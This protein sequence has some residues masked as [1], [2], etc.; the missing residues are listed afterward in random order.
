MFVLDNVIAAVALPVVISG[1]DRWP[2]IAVLVLAP[3]CS[4]VAC[5]LA[6]HYWPRMRTP[7]AL[8]SVV[9]GYSLCEVGRYAW[10]IAVVPE[11]LASVAWYLGLGG[12]TVGHVALFAI[13]LMVGRFFWTVVRHASNRTSATHY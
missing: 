2:T 7:A 5:G 10:L 3:T 11:E 1:G 8:V 9:V 4:G 13:G 6:M 12:T